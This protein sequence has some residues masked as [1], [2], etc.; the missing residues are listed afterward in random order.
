MDE[1]AK[2]NGETP[3]PKRVVDR[4]PERTIDEIKII[5]G[6]I[7]WPWEE[8]ELSGP[9]SREEIARLSDYLVNVEAVNRI[10]EIIPPGYADYRLKRFAIKAEGLDLLAKYRMLPKHALVM[11]GR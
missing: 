11:M 7:P 2:T 9:L 3:K 6:S 5:A 1:N 10:N 8:W 4:G